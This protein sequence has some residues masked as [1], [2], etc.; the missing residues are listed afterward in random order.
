MRLL[1]QGN[2]HK[3][4]KTPHRFRLFMPNIA[5][6]DARIDVEIGIFS[7]AA[8]LPQLFPAEKFNRI[9]VLYAVKILVGRF[10]QRNQNAGIGI[11][12][13]GKGL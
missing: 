5:Y 10:V 1:W 2:E 4:R 9:D 12:Q 3:Q 11:P 8:P 13:A 7:T 6:G